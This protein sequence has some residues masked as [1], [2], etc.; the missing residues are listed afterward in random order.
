LHRRRRRNV[1]PVTISKKV[2]EFV[3][4]ID[5]SVV[6]SVHQD[7]TINVVAMVQSLNIFPPLYSFLQIL[8]R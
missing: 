7:C 8:G 2:D 4:D 6:I 1:V 5:G 3:V